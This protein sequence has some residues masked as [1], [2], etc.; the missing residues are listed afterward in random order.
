[1]IRIQLSLS[2]QD[3]SQVHQEVLPSGAAAV[4]PAEQE[5]HH[6]PFFSTATCFYLPLTAPAHCH[7]GG[8]E[9]QTLRHECPLR[10]PGVCLP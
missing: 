4:S 8:S 1:M 10:L 5:G 3:G 6:A 9:G 7:G 2:S